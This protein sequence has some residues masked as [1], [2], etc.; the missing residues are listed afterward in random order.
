VAIGRL[1]WAT[2]V[3]R[4]RGNHIRR[5]VRSS[6]FRRTLAAA[7]LRSLVLV[8]AAPRRLDRD[9]ERRLR[10]WMLA[11]LEV[12]VFPF[13]ER[14]ALADL[15]QRVLRALDP[16]LNLGGMPRTATRARLAELRAVLSCGPVEPT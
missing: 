15:E 10:D 11:H 7:L 13:P 6:T 14:D 16:P 3:S 9:S 1:G 12:A 5:G 8:L 4:I 2:L